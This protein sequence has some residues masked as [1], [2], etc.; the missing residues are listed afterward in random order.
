[1]KKSSFTALMLGTVS[2][3]LFALGFCMALIP[4][5]NAFKPGIVFGSVGLLLGLI[6]YLL[7]RKMEHKNPIQISGKT[8]LT[9]LTGILGALTLGIG[10]CFSMVWNKLALGIGI[11]LTGIVIL[12]CLI[13]LTQGIKD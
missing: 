8:L 12:L 6:T 2:G 9:L 10:M 1:M 7:W 13:P 11:G 4:E 3:V 5:W